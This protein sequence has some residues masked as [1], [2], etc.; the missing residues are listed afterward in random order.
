MEHVKWKAYWYDYVPCGMSDFAV[1]HNPQDTESGKCTGMF[2]P[3]TACLM[4][5]ILILFYLSK[6]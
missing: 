5:N 6:V 4:L 1:I 2:I 3:C